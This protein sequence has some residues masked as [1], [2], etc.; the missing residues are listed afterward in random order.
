[1]KASGCRVSDLFI[2]HAARGRR[3]LI[4]GTAHRSGTEI[5]WALVKEHPDIGRTSQ[6]QVSNS[7]V[8]TPKSSKGGRRSDRSSVNVQ[9]AT[10]G[11]KGRPGAQLFTGTTGGTRPTVTGRPVSSERSAF[12]P[13]QQSVSCGRV[14][15]ERAPGWRSVF[16]RQ[17]HLHSRSPHRYA[18]ADEPRFHVRLFAL[19]RRRTAHRG[20]SSLFSWLDRPR[21]TSRRSC[22]RREI[23]KTRRWP[24][25]HP[26]DHVSHRRCKSVADREL[27]S[28]DQIGGVIRRQAS[29]QK[30]PGKFVG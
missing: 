22:S 7:R 1:V 10:K 14:R 19:H 9:S 27:T 6:Y 24:P 17:R 20:A 25:A 29:I 21:T 12:S 15:G 18:Q 26:R 8:T 2:A 23:D 11:N 13:M 3:G 28:D 30:N 5:F 16:P 4:L